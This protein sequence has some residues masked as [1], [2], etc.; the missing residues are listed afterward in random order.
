MDLPLARRGACCKGRVGDS[1]LSDQVPAETAWAHPRHSRSR[2]DRPSNASCRFRGQLP[3]ERA[4]VTVVRQFPAPAAC[5]RLP[6]LG[7]YPR[8]RVGAPPLAMRAMDSSRVAAS[9]WSGRY[10]ASAFGAA[11]FS[12]LAGIRWR[13]QP[14]FDPP[15]VRRRQRVAQAHCDA[16]AI[17]SR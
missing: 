4:P 1:E 2:A 9:E 16:S 14:I 3:T 17:K 12:R 13:G 10:F 5:A 7:A 8:R 15:P 11:L 6:R